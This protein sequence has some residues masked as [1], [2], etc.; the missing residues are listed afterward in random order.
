MA[1][2]C[3]PTK[4]PA[5]GCC[6][7]WACLCLVEQGRTFKKKFIKTFHF[8][9]LREHLYDQQRGDRER[10]C[11]FDPHLLAPPIQDAEPRLGR[12]H[13]YRVRA[14]RAPGILPGC[15]TK[16][17]CHFM[18]CAP[19]VTPFLLKGWIIGDFRL[20]QPRG[21]VK[22]CVVLIDHF[23]RPNLSSAYGQNK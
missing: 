7:S 13:Q 21:R 16:S 19:L 4:L 9:S 15:D 6:L 12:N 1:L 17:Q 10:F 20:C 18:L 8:L 22:T 3:A 2:L 14:F 5:G 11:T 23:K